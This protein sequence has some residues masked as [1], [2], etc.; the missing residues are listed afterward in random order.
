M[1]VLN[2]IQF[3]QQFSNF[4]DGHGPYRA[5]LGEKDGTLTKVAASRIATSIQ[6]C[7][8]VRKRYICS[9]QSVSCCVGTI[10]SG[11]KTVGPEMSFSLYINKKGPSGRHF[12]IVSLY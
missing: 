11:G 2:Q 1:P 8:R 10:D 3:S 6:L 5:V 4:A 9:A 12:A 7:A